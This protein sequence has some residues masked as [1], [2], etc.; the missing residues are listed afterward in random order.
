MNIFLGTLCI[1]LGFVGVFG[2]TGTMEMSTDIAGFLY[3]MLG[4]IAGLA[5]GFVGVV[6]INLDKP[7]PMATR[8]K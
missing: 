8:I 7:K 2:G 6:L 1:M 4:A 5:I 3:G